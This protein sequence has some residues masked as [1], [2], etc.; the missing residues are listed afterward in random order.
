LFATQESYF[1]Q[2]MAFSIAAS[3]T[4][5]QIGVVSSGGQGPAYLSVINGGTDIFVSN[6]DGGQIESLPWSS[7]GFGSPSPILQLKGSGPNPSRQTSAHPHESLQ[8]ESGGEVFVP[9]LGADKIWR[10]VRSGTTW[11]IAGS[12]QQP[13]GSGPRHIIVHDSMIYT[14]HELANTLTQHTLPTISSGTQPQLI[15]SIPVTPP[16]ANTSGMTAAELLISPST[17]TFPT[18]YLYASNRGDTNAVGDTIAIFSMN[19]L[20]LVAQVQTGLR[21]IR[22]LQIGGSD[23]QYVIAGGQ[24]SGGI[25]IFE[26]ISGGANLSQI[27]S[28]QGVTA[29]S[30]FVFL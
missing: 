12:I 22:G 5:S 19:P 6:Y 24:T 15:A 26:R 27:A 14:I 10:L 4:V 17:T 18:Q 7:A 13:S 21:A 1:G 23:G 25:K 3:G 28:I 29:P 8:V 16:G 30:T 11:T 20:A 2:V 9:D